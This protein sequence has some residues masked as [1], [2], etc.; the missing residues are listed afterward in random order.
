MCIRDRLDIAFEKMKL[1]YPDMQSMYM[2][3][4]T[5]DEIMLVPDKEVKDVNELK[6]ILYNSRI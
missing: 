4:S 1:D 5:K 2:M 6:N 3:V